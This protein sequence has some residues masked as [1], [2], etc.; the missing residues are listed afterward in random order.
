MPGHPGITESHQTP[1]AGT[2]PEQRSKRLNA[3]RRCVLRLGPGFDQQFDRCRGNRGWLPYDARA[4]L[5]ASMKPAD[6]S[7]RLGQLLDEQVAYYRALAPEYED[8]ALPL[9]GGDE[10]SAALDAFRPTGSVLE[11]AC[12]PGTWTGQLLRHATEI[13][14]VDASP[15]MLA[16]AS[17]RH[18]GDR[19]R[20]RR[21]P[22]P[23]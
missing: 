3:A 21:V 4:A 7:R 8:H 2:E 19:V 17:A 22:H 6:G 23:R 10:L 12:G 14:A 16:I 20:R 5:I 11:L 15:G 18:G 9:A 13:T 1:S